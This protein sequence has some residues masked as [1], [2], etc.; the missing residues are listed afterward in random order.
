MLWNRIKSLVGFGGKADPVN[1]GEKLPQTGPTPGK[2]ARKPGRT[3][4]QE[5]P[6]P[7]VKADEN[8]W[9][10]PLL[11]V[12]PVTLTA[13]STSTDPQYATN[14]ISFGRDDGTGFI[15]QEPMIARSIPAS[16]LFPIDRKLADGVL[17]IPRQM[18]H[19]W[20]LFYHQRKII[21]VR[22]WLRRVA[23]VA[24]VDERTGY[25]EIT[26]IRGSFSDENESP[27][28]TERAL[29]FLLR[30]HALG[31]PNY[32]APLPPGVDQQPKAVA[33]GCF[34]L[35]G[36]LVSYAT[37]YEFERPT[38]EKP[39]RT[40]SLLHIAVARGDV[41][42]V[43]TSLAAGVPADLLA[44]D[45]LAPL[46]WA[47]ASSNPEIVELLL[48]RGSPIDVRSDEDATPLMNAVQAKTL[49]KVLF[50]LARG[51]DPNACD[52]RGFTALHRAAEMGLPDIAKA[53]LDK[54]ASPDCDAEGH[55]ARSLATQRGHTDIVAL[56]DAH[57][58]T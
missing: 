19:K 1:T 4:L 51:A 40:H 8:P 57:G 38:P 52:R 48:E 7:L 45:G 50:L 31:I 25:I 54:Q 22:S 29:D 23:I 34:S 39:L 47:L 27:K 13:L 44:A 10:V 49:E 55:T 14:A 58:S 11:D 32:P 33:H 3:V 35:F 2:D 56:L 18:E 28:F 43:E 41:A 16:L 36:N 24:E 26:R 6:I 42:A 53:L 46:H 9:G 12:R 21:C 17:F 30:S 37:S 20:A 15:S 5:T